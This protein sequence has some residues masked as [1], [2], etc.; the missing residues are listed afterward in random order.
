[1]TQYT[2]LIDGALAVLSEADPW[3]KL[4]TSEAVIALWRSGDLPI[5]DGRRYAVPGRP[6]RDDEAVK[7]VSSG[8]MPKL[9][10]GG[11]LASRQVRIVAPAPAQL[12]TR[13]PHVPVTG[14]VR[15]TAAYL[16]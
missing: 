9:G 1:M 3:A 14:S 2:C 8:H 13:A 15:R 4:A 5:D 11:T 16:A 6:A 12:R 10:R 7:V